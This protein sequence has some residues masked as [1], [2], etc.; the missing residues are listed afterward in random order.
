MS[1]A[2]YGSREIVELLLKAGAKV[3]ARNKQGTTPL[4]NAARSGT[5]ENVRTLIHAGADLNLH[6]E[7]GH[8]ALWY[9]RENDDD[10]TAG[11]LLA[12]GA[13]DDP[14]SA[15]EETEEAPSQP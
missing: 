12:Y 2:E 1:A 14:P 10:E 13:Y 6:D 9:A 3:N 5:I 11:L 8:S 15:P 4:I 7:D